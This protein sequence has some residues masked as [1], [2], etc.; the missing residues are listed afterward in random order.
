MLYSF[1]SIWIYAFY[2]FLSRKQHYDPKMF[3][4]FA[5]SQLIQLNITKEKTHQSNDEWSPRVKSL[6]KSCQ[7]NPL[8]GCKD[9]ELKWGLHHPQSLIK[10]NRLAAGGAVLG[11]LCTLLDSSV[12]IGC[13]RTATFGESRQSFFDKERSFNLF[14]MCNRRKQ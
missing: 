9:K 2:F 7:R 3:Q 1:I 11:G 12:N 13:M 10:T 14:Y 8:N 6:L 4:H 5:F